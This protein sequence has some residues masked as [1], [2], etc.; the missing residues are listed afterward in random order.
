M[1]L[2]VKKRLGL[3]RTTFFHFPALTHILPNIMQ[4]RQQEYHV[5][6]VGAGI[7]GCS[8]AY[9]LSKHAS[10]CS[11]K[12]KISIVDDRECGSLTSSASTECY[13]NWWTEP[14]MLSF[15]GHS[16]ELYEEIDEE[17]LGAFGMNRPGYVFFS[18]HPDA[19]SRY[20]TEAKLCESLGAGNARTHMMDNLKHYEYL[21]GLS[22]K[23]PLNGIDV[24]LPN[25]SHPLAFQNWPSLRNDFICAKHVRNC[26]WISVQ[27]YL[28]HI[29]AISKSRGVSFLQKTVQGIDLPI[30]T[31]QTVKVIFSD[32]SQ[33]H[34]NQVIMAVG[35]NL[36]KWIVQGQTPSIGPDGDSVDN[37][38]LFGRP[39][40][41]FKLI[42][43]IHAKVI[44]KDA[45]NIIPRGA[46]LMLFDDPV[47]LD[48]SPE[49]V[50]FFKSRPDL[51]Y[52]LQ[53]FK[54]GVHFRPT[55]DGQSLVAI[56][57]YNLD[58]EAHPSAI[59]ENPYIDEYYGEIV[60][61]GLAHFVP[62]LRRYVGN[63]QNPISSANP[64][65][66]G[67]KVGYYCKTPENRPFIGPAWNDDSR[68]MLLGALSGFGIMTSPAAGE[69]IAAH[70]INHINGSSTL[71][72]PDYYKEFL[73]SRYTDDI[74]MEK[75]TKLVGNTGQ[76]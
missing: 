50:N 26:G 52:M 2:T 8:A 12:L 64:F 36:K 44:I 25:S 29:N 18:A 13:R 46:P 72:L 3:N 10:K 6:I 31:T 56:W 37:F 39:L 53:P 43:E 76:L 60:L 4:D 21:D 32:Q 22:P 65:I 59:S 24:L 49:Q 5:L 69:L 9:Q 7:A 30:N 41:S 27:R 51:A 66:E 61:R 14:T 19:P 23:R 58:V 38:S 75:L 57:T 47:T 74:Y 68:I 34:V 62:G 20:E 11:G 40:P 73:P 45:E 16:I 54:G 71:P 67:V 15:V 42:L 35:P 63:S 17:S 33:V 28:D 70:T 1:C 48:W 55:G